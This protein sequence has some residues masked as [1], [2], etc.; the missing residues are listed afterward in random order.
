M[1]RACVTGHRYI[2][3]NKPNNIA[4][5]HLIDLAL[6]DGIQQFYV[7]MSRGADFL[8]ADILSERNLNWVAIIPCISQTHL[9]NKTD[10]DKHKFLV[11][12][13]DDMIIL[14]DEYKRGVM[15]Y[16]NRYMVDNSELLLAIYDDSAKGGTFYTVN[17]ALK[18][19]KKVVQ[20]NPNTHQFNVLKS[21]Q[22]SFNLF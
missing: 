15:H 12:K 2:V 18:Q 13:A 16:R 14:H 3:K 7:G 5:N 10:K 21:R 8:F 11:D 22:L 20:F 17:L 19:H 4:I 9:W 1:K 6:K